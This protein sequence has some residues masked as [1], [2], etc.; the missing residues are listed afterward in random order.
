MDLAPPE[1]ADQLIPSLLERERALHRITVFARHCDRVGIAEEIR[2][3]QHH[4]VQSMALNPFAAVEKTAQRADRRIDLN[5]ERVLDR[6]HAAHLLDIV[7]R[8][9]MPRRSAAARRYSIG[10]HLRRHCEHEVRASSR[11]RPARYSRPELSYSP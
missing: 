10:P 8:A 5:A 3:V 1:Q 9:A 6:V 4:D 7:A 11:L 2:R